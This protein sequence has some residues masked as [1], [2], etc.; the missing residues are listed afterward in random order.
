MTNPYKF[1]IISRPVSISF[2]QPP[3]PH[4][5]KHQPPKVLPEPPIPKPPKPPKPAPPLIVISVYDTDLSLGPGGAWGGGSVSGGALFVQA[6]DPLTDIGTD[7][8]DAAQV[9]AISQA[10]GF[11]G[12]SISLVR[13]DFFNL[14]AGSLL[15]PTY[16]SPPPPVYAMGVSWS[17]TGSGVTQHGY[18]PPISI[19]AGVPGAFYFLLNLIGLQNVTGG[20]TSNTSI[21]RPLVFSFLVGFGPQSNPPL[22]PIPFPGNFVVEISTWTRTTN[23]VQ[24]RMGVP[25]LI[26]AGGAVAIQKWNGGADRGT[27]FAVTVRKNLSFTVAST[28]LKT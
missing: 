14:T 2:P 27:N 3:N 11:S 6:I 28:P 21:T 13:P 4:K 10:T 18:G 12:N 17:V 1:G 22:Q 20:G 23:F 9:G 24:V 16:S 5:F 19:D 8:V 25:V 15:L 7:A 26:G